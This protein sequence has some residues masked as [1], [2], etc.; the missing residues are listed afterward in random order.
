M[1]D[2]I[3]YLTDDSFDG[4]VLKASGP[5]L[6]DFWADWCAPCKALAPFLDDMA[7]EFDGKI[8]ITKLDVSHNQETAP[9]YG[10]R[11]IPTLMIFKQGE[12]VATKV[13]GLSKSQLKAFIESNL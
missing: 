11:N 5:V 6:V 4:E 2:K 13:G 3:V 12:L 7:E 9:K 8:K 1:S 10:I